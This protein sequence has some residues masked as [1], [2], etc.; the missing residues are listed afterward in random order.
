MAEKNLLQIVQD[1]CKR[2]GL[3]VPP[4][5]A[6]SGD[7]TTVQVV[8][9]L[10]EGIQEICDR[11]ALQQL[12]TRWNFTHANGTDFLALDL[13]AGASD[14]KYNAPLTIWNTATRLPLRGPATIQEWQQIIV[15]T[16][17]PAVYTYT[18]YGDAIRIYPVPGDIPGTVFS[19]FYQSKCGV[20]DGSAL[21][22]TY[23][24]D[25]Y[26]PRLPTYLIEAD[27]K[28]RWKKEKGLPYAEDFRTCESMLVDAVG[29]TPNPVLNL[30]SGDKQ[31]LPGIFVSPGSWNL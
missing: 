24:E 19:F 15:M 26:T 21:F 4:V 6:G 17:A 1:F 11:Y 25:S 10:N 12:M 9:L 23:E 18:L 27:L 14:W 29:R 20:T 22:E 5:A 28:W 30:D 16:V 8:A 31:Y 3:P 13:K 7:D 2:V